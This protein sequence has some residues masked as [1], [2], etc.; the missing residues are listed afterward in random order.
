MNQENR[1]LQ[2]ALTSIK[3]NAR[4]VDFGTIA[5]GVILVL[6]PVYIVFTFFQEQIVKGIYAGSLKG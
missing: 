3:S 4:Q 1:T 2:I 6:I 5:A